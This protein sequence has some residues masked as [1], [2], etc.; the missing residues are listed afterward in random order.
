MD[1]EERGRPFE[2]PIDGVLDL[3]AFQ[4]REVKTLLADYVEACL[5]KG[6]KEIRIIHGK[7]TGSLRR[8]VH[9]ALDRM[10]EV[11][12]YGPADETSG[13][14]GATIVILTTVSKRPPRG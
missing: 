13:S 3:H 6:I 7:G 12:S 14:W 2:I 1:R 4:P 11:V 8:T 10:K 9:A 5:E